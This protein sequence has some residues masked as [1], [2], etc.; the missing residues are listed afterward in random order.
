MRSLPVVNARAIEV[1]IDGRPV[2]VAEGATLLD[3]CRA[4]GVDVPTMCWAENLTPVNVCRVC[5]VELEGARTLVPA[6]SRRAEPGM[7]VQTDSP[8][9]RLSRKVVLELLASSVDLSTA[10]AI[11]GETMTLE[12][13][14]FDVGDVI[15]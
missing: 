3:A 8:R 5:V 2:R 12:L 7:K 6:C 11:P 4:A 15:K 14:V 9:V 1:A 13:M 10:P